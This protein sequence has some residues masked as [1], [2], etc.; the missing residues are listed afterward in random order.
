MCEGPP[1]G[2][3]SNGRSQESSKCGHCLSQTCSSRRQLTA[4]PTGYELAAA[5]RLQTSRMCLV[6]C[7][8][9]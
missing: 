7:D 9:P 2:K 4:W 8:C 3:A 5:G 6:R 1:E